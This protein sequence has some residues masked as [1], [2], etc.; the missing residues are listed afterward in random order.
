MT[1]AFDE[2]MSVRGGDLPPEGEVTITGADPVFST[3]FKI[4]ETCASVLAS[5][6]V[7]LSDIWELKTGR[8]QNVSVDTRHATVALRSTNYMQRPDGNGGY[9][10][11]SAV[12]N[13]ETRPLTQP[14]PTKNGRWFLLHFSLAHLAKRVR[15]VLGCDLTKRLGQQSCRPLE[16]A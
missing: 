10:L 6:G 4:G 1:A 7:S 3:R 9:G 13:L 16:R 14:W 11:V 12:T 8:R 5:I 15:G 2:L